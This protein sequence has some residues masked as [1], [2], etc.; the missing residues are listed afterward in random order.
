MFSDMALRISYN[1]W[2]AAAL[3]FATNAASLGLG[4]WF[5][6]MDAVHVGRVQ[7]RE[8][9]RIDGHAQGWRE[10]RADLATVRP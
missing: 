9:G 2:L 3:L 5:A 7:G 10:G 6:Y 1:F 8:E 4:A